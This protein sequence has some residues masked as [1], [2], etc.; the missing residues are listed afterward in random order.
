MAAGLNWLVKGLEWLVKIND[1]LEQVPLTVNK[2]FDRTF[3][4][5][6]NWTQDKVDLVCARMAWR[7]NVAVER[8]RQEIITTLINQYASNSKLLILVNI[9]QTVKKNPLK[10]IGLFFEPFIKPIK[11]VLEYAKVLMVEIPRLARN[12]A[13]IANSLPPAPPN[14]HINFNA[15]KLRINT[16]TLA[17]V[18]SGGDLPTP[19]EMFPEP[20]K[21]FSK[22]IFDK[23][24]EKAKA[25]TDKDKIIYK[26]K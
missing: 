2:W 12:L 26:K 24:F 6:E 9:V 8:K 25:I 23:S 5:A 4:S 11:T 15:F 1:W 13:N 3:K 16:I 21:V 14:P 19:E 10:A 22:K 20:P 7:V 18:T 17:D